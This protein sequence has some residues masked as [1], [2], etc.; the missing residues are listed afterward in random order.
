MHPLPIRAANHVKVKLENP[1]R[2]AFEILILLLCHPRMN[3]GVAAFARRKQQIVSS[4]FLNPAKFLWCASG[5]LKL[6]DRRRPPDVTLNR[7]TKYHKRAVI[8]VPRHRSSPSI[9]SIQYA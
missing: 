2:E 4:D 8:V 5:S 6:F 3:A 1:R 9:K 7:R